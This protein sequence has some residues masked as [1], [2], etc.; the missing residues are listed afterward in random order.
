MFFISVIALIVALIAY[1]VWRINRRVKRAEIFRAFA[2]FDEAVKKA[3]A[4]RKA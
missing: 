2:R 3:A 4:K 1:K